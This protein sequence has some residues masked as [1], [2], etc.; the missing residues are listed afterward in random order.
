MCGKTT[1]MNIIAGFLAL[2]VY[3]RVRGLSFGRFADAAALGLT[4]DS[5]DTEPMDRYQT[6]SEATSSA[7]MM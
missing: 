5:I 3:A 2:A 7:A 1:L 6:T 4:I